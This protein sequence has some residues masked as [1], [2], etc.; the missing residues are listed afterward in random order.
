[1][2]GELG[3]GHVA[4]FDVGA[5]ITGEV[6]RLA[7]NLEYAA[8][9]F[10][11]NRDPSAA[12]VGHLAGDRALPN[13]VEQF[14]LVGIELV[15]QDAGQFEGMTGRANAFVRLLRVFDFRLV[16]ALLGRQIIA[17]IFLGYQS[18]RILDG[19]LR[20]V[21]RIGTHVRDVAI[22][23]QALGHLH[24]PPGSETQF[25]IRF[26]LQRAGGERWIRL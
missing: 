17:A 20:Q 13:H 23:V 6:D 7:A 10:D 19:D 11:R 25:A 14:E 2:I 16:D 26:L 8:F 24:G 21:G 5:E 15:A 1:L 9:A 12:G 22:L 4:A 3:L 18:P